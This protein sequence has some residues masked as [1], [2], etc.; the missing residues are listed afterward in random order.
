MQGHNV[1]SQ[2]AGKAAE[3]LDSQPLF[4][5][6][7]QTYSQNIKCHQIPICVPR[8]HF[9]LEFEFPDD[10]PPNW[11]KEMPLE[12]EITVK[13]FNMDNFRSTFAKMTTPPIEIG[14]SLLIGRESGKPT[15]RRVDW[16]VSD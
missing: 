13:M 14:D 2:H 3:R 15:Q 4:L 9:E 16:V 11:M 1:Q 12:I 8:I 5:L 10:A 6:D 7:A